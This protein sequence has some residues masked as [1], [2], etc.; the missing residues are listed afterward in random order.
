MSTER[1]RTR[2]DEGL[3][4]SRKSNG[5]NKA[6]YGGEETSEQIM[7]EGVGSTTNESYLDIFPVLILGV[8]NQ[9]PALKVGGA[10]G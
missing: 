2:E 4:I 6:K 10:L 8:I 1:E 9:T 3:K 7:S 5:G